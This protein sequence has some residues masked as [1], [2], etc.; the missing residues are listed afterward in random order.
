MQPF[1][2]FSFGNHRGMPFG[3]GH[4]LRTRK[5]LPVRQRGE[6]RILRPPG[7]SRS[8]RVRGRRRRSGRG[9]TS[10]SVRQAEGHRR[11]WP[12]DASSQRRATGPCSRSHVVVVGDHERAAPG[13]PRRTHAWQRGHRRQHGGRRPRPL[14][15]CGRRLQRDVAGAREPSPG[16]SRPPTPARPPAAPRSPGRGGPSR[17]AS[18]APAA[19]ARAGRLTPAARR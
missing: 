15:A 5:R 1:D 9:S 7:F 4:E 13:R 14:A 17:S 3:I 12:R 19:A 16:L 8:P 2:V 10:C 11:W 18:V 6:L